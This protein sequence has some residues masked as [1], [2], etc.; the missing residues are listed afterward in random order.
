MDSCPFAMLNI[1]MAAVRFRREDLADTQEP[2]S[3]RDR[4]NADRVGV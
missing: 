3:N 2:K 4:N 1:A